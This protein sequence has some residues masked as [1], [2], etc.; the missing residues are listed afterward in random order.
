MS[1]FCMG[2]AASSLLVDGGG[3]VFLGIMATQS[4]DLSKGLALES[5]ELM[6]SVLK[7]DV[8][9]GWV[10]FLRGAVAELLV[11]AFLGAGHFGEGA[12]A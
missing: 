4:L 7:R 9:V 8:S 6:D 2:R 5:L 11:G 10:N 3:T 1:S 12:G